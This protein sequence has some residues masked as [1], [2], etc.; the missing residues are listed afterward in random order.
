MTEEAAVPQL[1]SPLFET[2]EPIE[3]ALIGVDMVMSEVPVVPLC[4]EGGGDDEEEGIREGERR[5]APVPETDNEVAP[6]ERS[7]AEA[8]AMVELP[9]MGENVIRGRLRAL[10]SSF[11]SRGGNSKGFASTAGDLPRHALASAG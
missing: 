8:I 3:V 9:V 6:S 5:R 11:S 4:I 2:G 10:P 7:A 1:S